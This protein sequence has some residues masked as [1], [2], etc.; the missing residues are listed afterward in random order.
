MKLAAN[1][2]LEIRIHGVDGSVETF[3]VDEPAL[4]DRMLRAIGPARIFT[5]ESITIAG[6]YSITAFVTSRI[7]RVDLIHE[8]FCTSEF[9]PGVKDIVELTEPEFQ[10]LIHD[11]KFRRRRELP[12]APG[13]H[14]LGFLDIEMVSGR[15]AYLWVESVTPPAVDRLLRLHAFLVAATLT[16]PLRDRG[17]A[18]LNLANMER[19]TAY[20]GPREV[21]AHAWPGHHANHGQED[22][23]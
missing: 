4:V 7:T 19:F 1:P 2:M 12:R 5:E 23:E 20:P 3:S 14:V 18:V 11:P 9:P 15:H 21:P 8:R 10:T 13:E 17:I 6:E 16:F 22:I